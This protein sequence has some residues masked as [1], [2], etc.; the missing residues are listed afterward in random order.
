[1]SRNVIF[2]TTLTF[3]NLIEGQHLI[4]TFFDV[5]NM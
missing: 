2:V 4:E 5:V 3:I 1:M